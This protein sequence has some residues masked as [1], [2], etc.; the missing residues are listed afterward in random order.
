MSSSA[1]ASR[2]EERPHWESAYRGDHPNAAA[3]VAGPVLG[4]GTTSG[5]MAAAVG[6]PAAQSTNSDKDSAS[7]ATRRTSAT[8]G[9]GSTSGRHQQTVSSRQ[10]GDVSCDRRQC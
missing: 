9:N 2:M 5:G 8:S 10:Q 7:V 4:G 3:A 6:L 1:S